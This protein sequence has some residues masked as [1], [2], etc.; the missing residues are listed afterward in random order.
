MT[1]GH[2]STDVLMP[3]LT[4]EYLPQFYLPALLTD[5]LTGALKSSWTIQMFSVVTIR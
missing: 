2:P 5:N 4:M 3:L 1:D